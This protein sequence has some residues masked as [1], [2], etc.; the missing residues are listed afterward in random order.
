MLREAGLTFIGQA[1]MSGEKSAVAKKHEVYDRLL[2]PDMADDYG[3]A[4]TNAD[5]AVTR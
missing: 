4:T 2:D 3:V 1:V 5:D